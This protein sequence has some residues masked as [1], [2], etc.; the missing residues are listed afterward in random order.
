MDMVELCQRTVPLRVLEEEVPENRDRPGLSIWSSWSMSS[1]LLVHVVRRE[2][3][4]KGPSPS[5]MNRLYSPFALAEKSLSSAAGSWASGSWGPIFPRTQERVARPG[6]LYP[7]SLTSGSA[8][9]NYH[10]LC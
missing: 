7:L 8:G 10:R 4:R 1:G 6:A 3:E 9:E 2:Q 5:Q